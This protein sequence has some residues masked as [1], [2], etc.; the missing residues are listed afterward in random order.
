[1]QNTPSDFIFIP[2]VAVKGI[3]LT[4]E[5]KFIWA[6]NGTLPIFIKFILKGN[7]TIPA[8]IYIKSRFKMM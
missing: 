1:M 7:M 3:L 2:T 5:Q 8:N 4:N 6:I